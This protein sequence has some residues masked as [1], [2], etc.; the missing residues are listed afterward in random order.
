MTVTS[1][2]TA[3]LWIS[4]LVAK[5][6][7]KYKVPF[8]PSPLPDIACQ[9]LRSRTRW[10]R[11]KD[12]WRQHRPRRLGC[13]VRWDRIP[14]ETD[15]TPTAAPGPV[16]PSQSSTADYSGRSSELPYLDKISEMSKS[17]SGQRLRFEFDM[18]VVL[19][20]DDRGASTFLE[21]I[22]HDFFMTCP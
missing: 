2:H 21:I 3:T 16:L 4:K 13:G 14:V 5:N 6:I 15:W 9:T 12:S 10:E 11:S 22:F 20:M 7:W 17:K 18:H 1:S 19:R 8:S